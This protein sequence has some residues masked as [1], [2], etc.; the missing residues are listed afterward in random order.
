M[1][2]VACVMTMNPT[3]RCLGYN[4]YGQLGIGSATNIGDNVGEMANVTGSSCRTIEVGGSSAMV[5]VI[6]GGGD[7]TCAIVNGSGLWCWG[8]NGFGQ[9]GIGSTTNVG[10][11]AGSMM[12]LSGI[13]VAGG[14]SCL[15]VRC[16][17]V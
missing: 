2:R 14:A 13:S 1:W 11:T 4:A 17:F 6:H 12:S 15:I 10:D 5:E 16:V 9:L 7:D 3:I 8:Y